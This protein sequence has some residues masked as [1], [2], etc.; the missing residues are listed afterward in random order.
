MLPGAACV[1]ALVDRFTQH[2]RTVD[3]E[4]DSWRQTKNEPSPK[5]KR[6]PKR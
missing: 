5:P 3:I 6:K 1:V 4:A 2:L